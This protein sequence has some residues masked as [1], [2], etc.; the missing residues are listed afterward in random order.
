MRPRGATLLEALVAL[1]I[2]GLVL[3]ALSGATVRARAA[4][5]AA[6]ARSDRVGAGRTLL[7]RLAT[8]LEAARRPSPGE[9]F[10]VEPPADGAP[11]W[12]TLSFPT[13]ARGPAAGATPA[14]DTSVVSYRVEPIAD[15]PGIGTLVRRESMAPVPASEPAAVP[16]L[17]GLRAL[18]VRCLDGGG[19]HAVWQSDELPRA[20]EIALAQD[21]GGGGTEE[22]VTSVALQA[23]SP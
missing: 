19:W 20:V 22:L 11:P 17:G 5:T 15:R 9:R 7:V 13:A 18:R 1:A 2:A 23:A 4:R 6:T 8:E 3:A 10:V 21:D 16:V 12:S 14:G